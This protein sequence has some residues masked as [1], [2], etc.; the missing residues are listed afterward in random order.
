VAL[1]KLRDDGLFKVKH[2]GYGAGIEPVINFDKW[3]KDILEPEK[4]KDLLKGKNDFKNLVDA[5]TEAITEQHTTETDYC[6]VNNEDSRIEFNRHI[7]MR[8]TSPTTVLGIISEAVQKDSTK[9]KPQKS[10]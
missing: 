5:F 7:V 9:K 8:P 4:F 3:G 10:K 1:L 2:I 6:I